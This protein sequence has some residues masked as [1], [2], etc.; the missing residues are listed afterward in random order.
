MYNSGINFAKWMESFH[1]F[2]INIVKYIFMQDIGA[3]MIPSYYNDKISSY[4]IKHSAICLRL[5]SKLV[6]LNHELKTTQYQQELA[7]TYLCSIPKSQN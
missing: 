2:V 7:L 3:T 1:S 6:Q 5:A 4:G